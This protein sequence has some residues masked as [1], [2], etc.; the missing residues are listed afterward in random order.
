[1]NGVLLFRWCAAAVLGVGF[2][3]IAVP[4]AVIA[5][6]GAVLGK[7]VP[8]F[9]P[10]FGGIMGAVALVIVPLPGISAYWWVPL[11]ADFGCIPISVWTIAWLLARRMRRRSEKKGENLS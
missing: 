8:S 6:K 9:L 11:I 10:F 4:H 2:V 3:S 5:F 7:K 1:M